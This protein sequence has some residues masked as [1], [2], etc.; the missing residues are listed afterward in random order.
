M[1]FDHI[2]DSDLTEYRGDVASFHEKAGQEV[3]LDV[4]WTGTFDSTINSRNL[5]L[6]PN[7]VIKVEARKSK[8]YSKRMTYPPD[9]MVFVAID[10]S[11]AM[12]PSGKAYM[13]EAFEAL[14]NQQRCSRGRRLI[15]PQ[16]DDE[17]R[18]QVKKCKESLSLDICRANFEYMEYMQVCRTGQLKNGLNKTQAKAK[19]AANKL[20]R[21]A[22][23]DAKTQAEIKVTMDGILSFFI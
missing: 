14:Q 13:L 7:T 1:W 19:S 17:P 22:E 23:Q 21:Q 4:A 12:G 18:W 3:H 2:D 16:G 20:K 15:T 5:K 10:S 6:P 9:C 11:G 8:T